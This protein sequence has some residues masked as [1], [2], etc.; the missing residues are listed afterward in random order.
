MAPDTFININDGRRDRLAAYAEWEAIWGP[1][2]RSLFGIRTDN[3]LMNT[4]AVHGYNDT[5]MYNGAP[6]YPATTFNG[7]DRKRT[8]NNID[9]TALSRYAP[10]P[11]LDFEAGYARKTRS[12]NL[13]ERYAWSTNT[14][15]MEMINFAGDGNYYVGNL[16]LVPET[17]HTVSAS[18]NWHAAVTAERGIAVTPYY[19]VV[20]DYVDARRCPTSVC[21]S[22][23]AVRASLTA[24]SG[25]VYL[26]FVN[27]DSELY[28][29]D[30]SGHSQL[31]RLDRYGRFSATGTLSVVRGRY[32]TGDDNLYN[33]MPVTARLAVVHAL[34]GWTNVLD[35][36][37][38]GSKTN[39]SR[40]RNEIGTGGYGLVA[41]RTSYG[42]KAARIDVGVE[43]LLDTFYSPPLGGTYV[44]Q[45]A[46]MSG[47]AIPW[48]IPIAGAG[49][50]L[51]VNLSLTF[52]SR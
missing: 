6:L 33:I 21:G 45:G 34:G 32:H 38:V 4:G 18:A 52:H 40:V 15:A 44:G 23:A 39:L 22:S 48:G 47:S 12:P 29:V 19:T 49:R 10:S 37:L 14:M 17:A 1:K 50:A 7:R 27:Q 35:V 24:T 3:V 8:D 28:G 36:Q 9:V 31:A 25:F 42:W 13:Y 41:L 20:Q 16:D 30:V 46:T 5:M 26:Q 51:Y 43:N 11:T 2:W